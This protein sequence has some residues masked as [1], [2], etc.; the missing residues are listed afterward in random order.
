M[1]LSGQIV[2]EEGKQEVRMTAEMMV[3]QSHMILMAAGA[4]LALAAFGVV[5]GLLRDLVH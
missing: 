1:K 3:V 2:R 5:I 4:G